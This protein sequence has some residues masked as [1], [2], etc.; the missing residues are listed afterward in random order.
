ME[1]G[2]GSLAVWD[3]EAPVRFAVLEPLEKVS[4]LVPKARFRALVGGVESRLGRVFG[5]SAVARLAVTQ[6]GGLVSSAAGIGAEAAG[7]VLDATLELLGAATA[8]LEPSG[9]RGRSAGARAYVERHLEDPALGPTT[10]AAGLG[11]ST[12]TLQAWFQDD[13]ISVS[14]YIRARRLERAKDR[15]RAE[16]KTALTVI[17]LDVGFKDPSHFSRAFRARFGMSPSQMRARDN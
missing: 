3:S 2:P 7:P 8:P 4:L 1:L 15:I 17:G 16:P 10:L 12:R 6:L 14:A 11:V 9:P 5:M 13:G